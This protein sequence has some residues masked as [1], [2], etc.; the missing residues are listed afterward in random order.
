VDALC[1]A[2]VRLAWF[3]Q[4]FAAEIA[5]L[6]IN[7]LVVLPCAQGVKLVDALILKS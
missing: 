4:D 1:D 7:P 2:I 5:E 3:A 6:D